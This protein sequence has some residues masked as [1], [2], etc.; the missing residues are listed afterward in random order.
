[1]Y[2][3]HKRQDLLMAYDDIEVE[4]KLKADDTATQAIKAKLLKNSPT[5]KHHIDTYFD[6]AQDSFLTATPIREWLSVRQ[7]GDK[8]IINYKYWYF[9]KNGNST[10]CDEPELVVENAEAA[11][12]LLKPLGFEPLVTVNK[13]RTEALINNFLVAVDEVEEL[14]SF[15]EIEATKSYGSIQDTLNTLNA[16]A[17]EL[18]LNIADITH[19]GYPHLLLEHHLGHELAQ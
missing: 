10:H 13:H 18:G 1:M 5:Q 11:A 6:K 14:G 4:I 16:F 8:V 15:V 19:K 2:N 3:T 7:R 17:V 12:R 9:D